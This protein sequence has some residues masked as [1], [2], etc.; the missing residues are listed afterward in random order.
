M[1]TLY[2]FKP[3]ILSSSGKKSVVR[4]REPLSEIHNPSSSSNARGQRSSLKLSSA[5]RFK[6]AETAGKDEAADAMEAH[7][8]AQRRKT[9][10][11]TFE[12]HEDCILDIAVC[13]SGRVLYT[14]S[15]DKT[16]RGWEVHSGTC[17]KTYPHSSAV[18]SVSVSSDGKYLNTVCCPSAVSSDNAGFVD[19]R[20]IDAETGSVLSSTSSHQIPSSPVSFSPDGRYLYTVVS[21]FGSKFD[22]DADNNCTGR[23]PPMGIGC[24]TTITVSNCGGYVFT[25][26]N[27]DGEDGYAKGYESDSARTIGTFVGHV[28]KVL[29]LAQSPDGNFLFTC[30]E[31]KT[32]K[33]FRTDIAQD[34]TKVER[35]V[36]RYFHGREMI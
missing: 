1:A 16:L 11:M 21:K 4:S 5:F 35:A 33:M 27:T 30:G 32:A 28:G 31:D 10:E 13:P 9:P 25:V 2:A 24:V 19:L 22:L 34:A 8:R 6:S 26:D 17:L 29:S 14:A 20:R 12:G 3:S 36:P 23:Y 18:L 15:S 7:R